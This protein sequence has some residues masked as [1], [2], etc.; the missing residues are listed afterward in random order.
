MNKNSHHFDFTR[1]WML[2]GV[3]LLVCCA[4]GIS[5]EPV[6]YLYSGVGQYFFNTGVYLHAAVASQCPE[7]ATEFHKKQ[8]LE[9]NL[10]T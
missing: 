4:P 6:Q 3:G 7:I 5:R 8:Q 9:F 1:S 2:G 10:P